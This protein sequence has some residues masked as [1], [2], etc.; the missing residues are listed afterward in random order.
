MCDNEVVAVCNNTI[1]SYE[2]SCKPEYTGD[3]FNCT[4]TFTAA[5]NVTMVKEVYTFF[6]DLNECDNNNGGCSQM[7]N[8][9]VGSFYCSCESGYYL[10]HDGFTCNG[11]F[12][13]QHCCSAS[14]KCF[15]FVVFFVLFVLLLFFS[16][17]FTVPFFAF[18]VFFCMSPYVCSISK[19]NKSVSP[20]TVVLFDH[21]QSMSETN[22]PTH[23]NFILKLLLSHLN[24]SEGMICACVQLLQMCYFADT[25]ECENNNTNNCDVINGFCTN[26]IGSFTCAC[27]NG[28]LGDGTEGNCTGKHL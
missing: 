3:G 24:N 8:N 22:L 25:N 13:N 19:N 27:N 9:I 6:T 15:F 16:F 21:I 17:S 14:L 26:T 1:G 20:P 23:M 28:Y 7:C 12:I 5:L 4:G 2:C 11:E 10:L 18:A